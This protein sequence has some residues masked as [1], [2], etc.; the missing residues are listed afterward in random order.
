VVIAIAL[1]CNPELLISDEPTSALD[2]TI[3]AQVLDTMRQLKNELR[4]S[5]LMITH[6]LGVVAETSDN[7]AVMYAGEIVEYGTLKH[8]F[9][10]AKH[11]YTKALFDAL[12]DINKDVDRLKPIKGLTP[13][14]TNLPNHCSF[15]ERCTARMDECKR[16]DPTVVD[17]GDGHLV[18]CLLFTSE[19]RNYE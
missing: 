15:Y 2:V 19:G 1:A 11:P 3:Q 10:D 13:D 7:V 17:V 16:K 6:D 12:P 4:T 5:M 8:I 9:K 18:K 14:P